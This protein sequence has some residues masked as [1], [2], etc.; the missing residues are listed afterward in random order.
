MQ[1]FQIHTEYI[2]LNQLLKLLNWAE[3]GSEANGMID[4]GL[5]KVNGVTESRKRNKIYP[6]M[7][8]SIGKQTVLVGKTP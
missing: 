1:E 6:G 7:Q 8:V 3:S 2:Q 4:S 5:V